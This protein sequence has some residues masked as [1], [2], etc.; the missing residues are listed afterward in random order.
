METSRRGVYRKRLQELS[1]NVKLGSGE[2]THR[3]S[4]SL[5]SKA[6][7]SFSFTGPL[8]FRI[9]CRCESSKNSTRTWVTPPRDPVLPRTCFNPKINVHPAG[10]KDHFGATRTLITFAS[11]TGVLEASYQVLQHSR[12]VVKSQITYHL[13]L[14]GG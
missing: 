1:A 5:S 2:T 14:K 13:F 7:I 3:A 4:R 8:T 10:T 12:L 11:F 6:R 9:S